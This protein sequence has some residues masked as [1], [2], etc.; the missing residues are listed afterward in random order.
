MFNNCAAE[1]KYEIILT[2]HKYYKLIWT[3]S[4]L[5]CFPV[6][7]WSHLGHRCLFHEKGDW[8]LEIAPR[9]SNTKSAT[10]RWPRS[11]TNAG[12]EFG[13]HPVSFPKRPNSSSYRTLFKMYL[14]TDIA[15][16]TFL[17]L[18]HFDNG[19]HWWNSEC[20]WENIL[21][22][23]CI[24][25][26]QYSYFYGDTNWNKTVMIWRITIERKKAVHKKIYIFWPKHTFFQIITNCR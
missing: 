4:L 19:L 21:P 9:F 23:K 25:F 7:L 24:H 5:R 11:W 1:I 14:W 12:H 3:Y 15:A 17:H 18:L 13:Y 20:L 2:L 16:K 22:A 8:A 10:H 26:R 6:C